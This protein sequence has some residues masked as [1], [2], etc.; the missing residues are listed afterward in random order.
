MVVRMTRSECKSLS[1]ILIILAS[2]AYFAL[3]KGSSPATAMES[4]YILTRGEHFST[5]LLIR[6]PR[7]RPIARNGAWK[8][9]REMWL[10]RGNMGWMQSRVTLKSC[11]WGQKRK[12][13]MRW[14]MGCPHGQGLAF[15]RSLQRRG[16]LVQI[17]PRWSYI[18]GLQVGIIFCCGKLYP[19]MSFVQPDEILHYDCSI[20]IFLQ[21]YA[22]QHRWVVC[23]EKK[24]LWLVISL[25]D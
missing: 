5:V 21:V 22:L 3:E 7:S 18:G 19:I 24:V 1:P 23:G 13:F 6:H 14:N 20:I 11:D 17:V 4:I 15:I 16:Y 9:F 8:K 2:L 10:W 12:T 25:H